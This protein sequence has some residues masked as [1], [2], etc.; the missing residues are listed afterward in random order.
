MDQPSAVIN[1]GDKLIGGA[2]TV[3][4]AIMAFFSKRHIDSMDKLADRLE[5]IADDMK[6]IKVEIKTLAYR[7]DRADERLHDL[8]GK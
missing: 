1:W 3:M 5:N 8:E 2:L 6:D 7:A 4:A